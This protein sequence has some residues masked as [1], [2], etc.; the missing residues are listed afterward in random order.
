MSSFGQIV[1]TYNNN[2]N[3][4]NQSGV[5]GKNAFHQLVSQHSGYFLKDIFGKKK[6]EF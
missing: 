3:S 6:G 4:Y 2:S 1:I 5:Y